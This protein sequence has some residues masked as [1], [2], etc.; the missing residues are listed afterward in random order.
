MTDADAE[1]A[2]SSLRTWFLALWGDMCRIGVKALFDGYTTW[3]AEKLVV[4]GGKTDEQLD[5][6]VEASGIM[7]LPLP[8]EHPC[9]M[10][11]GGHDND[12]LR[13]GE[14]QR[15]GV[16]AHGRKNLR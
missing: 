5:Q 9:W 12:N 10:R 14:R 3:R 4:T 1:K 6:D 16:G 7:G 11:D 15:F 13:T 8:I 2:V